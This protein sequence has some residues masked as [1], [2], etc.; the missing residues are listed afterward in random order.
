MEPFRLVAPRPS[1]VPRRLRPR[2]RQDWRTLRIDRIAA[3]E[4]TGTPFGPRT[5]PFDDVATW[6]RERVQAAGAAGRHHVEV[7]VEAPADVVAARV[8]RWADVR[9]RTAGTCTMT[10]DTD[11][12]DGPLWALGAAGAPF[13]VVSPPELAA[14]AAAWGAHFVRAGAAPPAGPATAT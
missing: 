6:V 14:L 8:G 9:P 7:V 3:A 12:L 11:A 1:L 5:P 2:P 10:L 4:G 13:T